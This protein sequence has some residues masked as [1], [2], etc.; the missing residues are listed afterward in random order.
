VI[1]HSAV[2]S[3]HPDFLVLAPEIVDIE[4]DATGSLKKQK[5]IKK[6]QL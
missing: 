2:N 5:T 1:A 6:M 4:E 3:C